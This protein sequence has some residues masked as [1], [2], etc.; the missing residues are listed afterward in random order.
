VA[1]LEVGIR[2][3]LAIYQLT[4]ARYP[5]VKEIDRIRSEFEERTRQLTA[6]SARN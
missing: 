2:G 3:L 1:K 5:E 4:Y 6:S